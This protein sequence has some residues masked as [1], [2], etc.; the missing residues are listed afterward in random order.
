MAVITSPGMSI[1]GT[2]RSVG[3]EPSEVTSSSTRTHSSWGGGGDDGVGYSC[4]GSN[5][6]FSEFA[7]RR[8]TDPQLFGISLSGPDHLSPPSE[9]RA[10]PRR[11]PAA[12]GRSER[13]P[14]SDRLGP[15]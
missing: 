2:R 10:G 8:A 3:V 13:P 12:E 15:D 11:S 14:V 4:L 6:L 5:S 7:P 1:F 9:R